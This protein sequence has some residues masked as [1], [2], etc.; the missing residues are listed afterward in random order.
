MIPPTKATVS[1]EELLKLHVTQLTIYGGTTGIK[2]EN[3]LKSALGRPL[4]GYYSDVIE[5]AAALWHSLNNNHGFNDGNKRVA[6]QAMKLYLCK[7]NVSIKIAPIE[8]ESFLMCRFN[9]HNLTHEN[10]TRF[11]RFHLEKND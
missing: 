6:Y 10:L 1:Y 8:A 7:N 2:D 9:E 3:L 4:Q 11:L 5:E